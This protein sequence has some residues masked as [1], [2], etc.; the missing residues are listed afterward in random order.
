MRNWQANALFLAVLRQQRA[1]PRDAL[2]MKDQ[3]P[4][5]DQHLL[6]QQNL[7]NFLRARRF[8]R[9]FPEHCRQV[10]D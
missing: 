7:Q 10:R 9:Q 3:H 8:H 2:A 1:Q 6:A 5:S 4:R